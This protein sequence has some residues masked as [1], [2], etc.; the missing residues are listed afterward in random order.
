MADLSQANVNGTIYHLKDAQARAALEQKLD[1]QQDAENAGKFLSVDT[2]G[3]L[4][5]TEGSGTGVQHE[6]NGTTLTITSESGTS[7]VDL[8]GAK[9]ERGEKGEKGETGAAGAKGETGAKGAPFT[10]ADFTEEQLAALKG[11]KG[12]KGETGETGAKG[13]PF[14]YADFTAEQLAALKGEKGETGATGAKGDKGDPGS[15]LMVD[16][17]TG[18]EDTMGVHNGGLYYQKT[19]TEGA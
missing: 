18:E 3:N 6:W 5:F 14:T 8:K 4:I 15:I 16:D 7:S 11:E 1:K 9:G 2:E 17:A 19:E 10:Y 13:E 12:D